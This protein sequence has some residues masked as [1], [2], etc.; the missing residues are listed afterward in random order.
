MS[1]S[2][3]VTVRNDARG[4]ALVLA[5]L[6]EQTRSPAEIIVVDG[7]STDGT[8]ETVRDAAARDPR[9]RRIDA[10]GANIARGRNIG[11]AAA[12]GEIIATTDAGCRAALDWLENLIEPF[13]QDPGVEFVA[14]FYR[15]EPHSLL[16]EVVGLATMRGQLDPVDAE[17]F[18]PSA[19]SVAYRKSLW[20][21][22]GGLPEWLAFSEDTL[23]DHKVRRLG[24]CWRFA[25]QAVVYWRPRGSLRSIARQFYHYGTGRGHT[26]IG[27]ADFHYHLRNL[28]LVIASAAACAWTHWAGAIAAVLMLYFYVWG[29]HARARAV[30]WKIGRRGAYALCLVVLWVVMLSNLAGYVV[31]TFQRWSRRARY[32]EAMEAYLSI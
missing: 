32:R 19:R 17:S 7:G 13:E 28:G 24:A 29:F 22:A 23:F 9:V 27:A 11:I 16:E 25:P 8:L 14:G 31:G 30:R 2:V 21:R 18:N 10:P 12:T 1:V 4:C 26:R 15:I 3:V 6:T 20:S 5:S